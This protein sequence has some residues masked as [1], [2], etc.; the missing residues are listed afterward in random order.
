MGDKNWLKSLLEFFK[1]L[2][3]S[4]D[5]SKKNVNVT[6]IPV[7]QNINIIQL[8]NFA[9]VNISTQHKSTLTQLS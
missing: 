2:V 9:Y 8:P 3:M 6:F 5:A 4:Y 1:V 7:I